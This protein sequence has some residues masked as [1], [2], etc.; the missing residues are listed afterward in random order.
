V[1]APE[2][3]DAYQIA[4][5]RQGR[6]ARHTE[7]ETFNLGETTMRKLILSAVAAGALLTA[8][9]AAQA[10]YWT[11]NYYG[12]PVYVATCWWGFFGPVCG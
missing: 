9:S 2:T 12:Q 6:A 5:G 11:V 10:G 1:S 3:I 4:H 7:N 8:A